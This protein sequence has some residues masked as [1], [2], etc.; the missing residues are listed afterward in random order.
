MSNLGLYQW[1]T[2]SMKKC[3]GPLKF[4]GI[5]FGTGMAAYAAGEFV[6]KKFYKK[7]KEKEDDISKIPYNNVTSDGE[8]ESTIKFKVGDKIRILAKVEGGA[9]IEKYGDANNPYMIS[10]ELL[11]Q[12]LS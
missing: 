9:L 3:G 10:N 5:V 7:W 1:T 11:K 12:I 2:T 4:L 8:D 6:V